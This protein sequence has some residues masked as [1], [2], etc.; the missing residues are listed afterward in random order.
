MDEDC[1][2][3]YWRQQGAYWQG[4]CVAETNRLRFWRRVERVAY[5]VLGIE[6]VVV[7]WLS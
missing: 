4:Q 7:L 1:T 3:E 5:V 6:I 2:N